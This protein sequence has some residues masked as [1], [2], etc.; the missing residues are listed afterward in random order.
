MVAAHPLHELAGLS[1]HLLPGQAEDRFITA[2]G[3]ADTGAHSD[4]GAD[5]Q[6]PEQIG[7]RRGER[8]QLKSRASGLTVG[9]EELLSGLRLN[10]ATPVEGAESELGELQT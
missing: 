1:E 7:R 10:P 2:L 4:F 5:C 3:D 8:R 9:I 6:L